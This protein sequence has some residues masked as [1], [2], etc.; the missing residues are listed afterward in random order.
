MDKKRGVMF[1]VFLVVVVSLVVLLALKNGD[2]VR[3]RR[4]VTI[5][6]EEICN[7]CVSNITD[8]GEKPG[9]QTDY[10]SPRMM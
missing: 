8:R 2:D 3:M 6:C 10:L 9:G 7:D 4:N 5:E 1:Y